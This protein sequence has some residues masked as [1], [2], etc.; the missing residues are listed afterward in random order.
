MSSK[1]YELVQ[2][3]NNLTVDATGTIKNLNN[4]PDGGVALRKNYAGRCV[5]T[6]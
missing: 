4:E 1:A 2:L 5:Y 6:S 3:A